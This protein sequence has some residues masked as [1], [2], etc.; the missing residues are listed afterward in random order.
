MAATGCQFGYSGNFDCFG[1]LIF[2]RLQK[3]APD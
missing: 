1:P 2:L 3:L